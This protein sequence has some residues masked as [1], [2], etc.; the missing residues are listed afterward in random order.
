MN[1]VEIFGKQFRK[2]R[3]ALGISQGEVASALGVGRSVIS[4]WENGNSSPLME[5]LDDISKVLKKP[6]AFFFEAA[7]NEAQFGI[8]DLE[9]A[10]VLI[11][12]TQ[13][14]I[15]IRVQAEELLGSVFL[16]SRAFEALSTA[17][18]LNHQELTE[19]YIDEYRQMA[20]EDLRKQAAFRFKKLDE[21]LPESV[22]DNILSDFDLK[23]GQMLEEKL[24]LVN[25]GVEPR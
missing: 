9:L 11:G 4:S 24:G 19:D 17:E 25:K 23:L 22:K 15:G 13:S 21:S 8:G 1:C 10:R 20:R 16:A 18:A 14:F 2:A 7:E 6:I 12:A 5:R 3:T